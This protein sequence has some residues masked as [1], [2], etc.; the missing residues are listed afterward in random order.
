M[1]PGAQQDG[2]RGR[3]RPCGQRVLGTFSAAA[4]ALALAIR[5]PRMV[6][7]ILA[8]IAVETGQA[9]RAKLAQCSSTVR[10]KCR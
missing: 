1:R 7:T 6:A 9:F 10:N 2:I 4:L 5:Y 3:V 8:A